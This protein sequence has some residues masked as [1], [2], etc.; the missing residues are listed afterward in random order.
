MLADRGMVLIP[1]NIF[2]GTNGMP[3]IPTREEE[4]L[5]LRYWTARWRGFWN[6][7]YQ[8]ASEWEEGFS[9]AEIMRIGG[10]LQELVGG[11]QLIS[12]HSL[13]GNPETVQTAGWFDYHTVQDKLM[14]WDPMRFTSLVALHR[15]VRK[16]IFAHECLWEGNLYQ[17]EAGLDL[18][19]LRRGAWVI[20]LSGGQINYADE[21]IPP[22]DYQRRNETR[23]FYALVGAAMEPHGRLYGALKVLSDFMRAI[24]FS[25]M[26]PRPELSSTGVC[27]AEPEHEY[28]VYIERGG[29]ATLDL[30]R[31]KGT[32]TGRWLNPRDGEIGMPFGVE[33]GG[34]RK[35]AAPNGDD[36]V[37]HITGR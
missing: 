29:T 28:V 31:A 32:L 12:A 9:E 23:D 14:Q 7:T 4:D 11:Q 24:P 36:W 33:P 17:K 18:D 22:R 27:L 37:L 16:P 13:T 8:P 26:V 19:N 30:T 5:F 1:F 20:A 2:G 35:F 34:S 21:V 25:R 10:K 6:A 3:K 15:K